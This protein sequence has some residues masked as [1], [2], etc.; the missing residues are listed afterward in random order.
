MQLERDMSRS[1]SAPLVPLGTRALLF[2][3]LTLLAVLL[4]VDDVAQVERESQGGRVHKSPRPIRLE[5]TPGASTA[6]RV[7][8]TPGATAADG[9]RPSGNWTFNHTLANTI[10]KDILRFL[11]PVRD[12]SILRGAVR[13]GDTV[14]YVL[15]RH[16]STHISHTLYRLLPSAPPL[17]R[18]HHRS[19]AIVGNSGILLNSHCGPRIDQH[20]FVIRCN[21]A[22]VE[23]FVEDVGS[24]TDLVTMNPSVV[25]RAFGDLLT[26]EWRQRFARRLQALGGSVLWVPAFMAKGGEERVEWTLNMIHEQGL[27]V[28]TAV[29]S[30][31]L[32]HA[33]RGYWLTQHVPIK[34]PSTGLLMYTLA[35][36]FCSQ[37]HLYGFWPFPLDPA[38]QPVKY[39]YYDQLTYQYSS[40]T[41][42]HAMPLEYRTL[43]ALH[44]QGALQLHTGPCM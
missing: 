1:R 10:R 40:S 39:H 14:H 13:P 2:A 29:P 6:V 8:P 34:R 15:D 43:R 9:A 42:P 33:V 36:R 3:L 38:G 37:L 24:R 25:Q 32:L 19:C 26:E 35:T 28:R 23:D 7:E 21:L 30:L 27:D 12:M 17:R 11:D 4:I 18:Q 5:P 22:P 20:P 31:R 41:G 16:A 44:R